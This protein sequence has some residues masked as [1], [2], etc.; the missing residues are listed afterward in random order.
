M[1]MKNADEI[2][3]VDV[4]AAMS[5]AIFYATG[6]HLRR[7]PMTPDKVLAALQKP[8]WAR[9]WPRFYSYIYL[10]FK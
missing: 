7:L 4:A 9:G 6:R 3:I 2:A 1:G 8:A 10:Y 5:S